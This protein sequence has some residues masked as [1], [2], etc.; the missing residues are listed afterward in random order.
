M[1]TREMV[2]AAGVQGL[3]AARGVEERDLTLR[4]DFADAGDGNAAKAGWDAR[5][6]AGRHGEEEFVIFA[7][8]EGAM[9]RCRLLK[10]V[11]AERQGRGVDNSADFAG[12]G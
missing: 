1:G 8:V 10:I 3:C 4:G 6:E 12:C 2:P 11:G 7:A 9:Q 5:G